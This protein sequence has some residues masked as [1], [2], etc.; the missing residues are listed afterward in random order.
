M[1]RVSTGRGGVPSEAPEA[2]FRALFDQHYR[3]IAAYFARRLGFDEALDAAD[4]VFVVAWRRLDNIPTGSEA[5]RW[6]FGVARNVLGN[7]RRSRFRAGR[8]LA[9]LRGLGR[10]PGDPGPEP[11]LIRREQDQEVLDALATLSPAEQELLRLA[12][13]EEL[14]HREIGE[15]LGCSRKAVDTRVYR[16]MHHLARAV[17]PSGHVRGRRAAEPVQEE[18]A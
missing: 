13:W 10:D 9:R 6:L 14:S 16:A 3:D 12:V 11:Q 4:D 1:Y 7:R 18:S 17:D 2:E 15:I 8:L 5:R